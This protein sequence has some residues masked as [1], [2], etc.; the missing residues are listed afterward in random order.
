MFFGDSGIGKT[1]V[2]VGLANYGL[3]N[4]TISSVIFFDFDNGLISLKKKE[5]RST[6]GKMGRI[7]I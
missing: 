6:S 7:E 2:S 4:K 1:L 3:E 5:I